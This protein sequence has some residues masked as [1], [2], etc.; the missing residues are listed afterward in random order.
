MFEMINAF[1]FGFQRILTFDNHIKFS[2]GSSKIIDS[3]TPIRSVSSDIESKLS[4]KS[5]QML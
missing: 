2:R 5:L 1:I 4:L 3:K